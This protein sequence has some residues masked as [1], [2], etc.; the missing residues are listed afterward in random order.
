MDE[1]LKRM[2]DSVGI[3]AATTSSVVTEA[4]FQFWL[5]VFHH[6]PIKAGNTLETVSEEAICRL[7]QSAEEIVSEWVNYNG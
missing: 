4:L 3:D 5:T 6:Y 7:S 1:E 2:L